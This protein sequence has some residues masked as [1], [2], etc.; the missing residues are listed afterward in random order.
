[1]KIFN[2]LFG[3]SDDAPNR[4]IAWLPLTDPNQ[5]QAIIAAS[6]HRPVVIFKH[7]TRCG[8]SRMALGN[9]EKAFDLHDKVTPYFLDLLQH[10]EV[11][12]AVSRQFDVVHQSPQILLISNGK[13]LYDASHGDIDATAL[14]NLI[15]A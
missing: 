14:E 5:L 8:I 11:S 15:S 7:S 9:F 6:R 1:M 13:A 12:D 3:G 4:R 2:G 10:R